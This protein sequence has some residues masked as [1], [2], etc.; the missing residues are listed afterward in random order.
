MHRIGLGLIQYDW[1]RRHKKNLDIKLQSWQIL[2]SGCSRNVSEIKEC[3]S[4]KYYCKRCKKI[5]CVYLAESYVS[6]K[7]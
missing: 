3:R 6:T 5:F 2:N 4:M 1:P 7:D